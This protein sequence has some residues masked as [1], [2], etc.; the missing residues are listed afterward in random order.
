VLKHMY[1]DADI[2]V[3]QLSIDRSR[4]P[5]YL[6]RMMKLVRDL[7]KKGVL[8]IGSGN[9]THNL[10]KV[11]PEEQAP[12]MD[13]AEEFDAKVANLVARGDHDAIVNYESW[14]SVSRQAHPSNDHFLPLIYTLGIARPEDNVR[15]LHEGFQ[16]GSISMRC[17]QFGA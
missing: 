13:W 16:H 5:D 7:R 4:Q 3:F 9:I 11:A 15:F 17:I 14:G 12:V 6:Y 8:V 1:P 2:P 10:S